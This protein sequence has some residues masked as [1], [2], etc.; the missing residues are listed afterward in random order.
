[1]TDFQPLT[2]HCQCGAVRYRVTAPAQRFYHCHCAMCRRMHGSLFATYAVVEREH[3]VIDAGGEELA[4]YESSPG[5][6]RKRCRNCACQLFLDVDWKPDVV[7]YSPATAEGHPGHA[8]E[9]ECHVFV[10]SK[11]SWHEITDRLPRHEEFP[12]GD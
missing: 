7:W 4:S 3:L 6:H 2:G 11:A 8:A 5:V 1:M 10:G 9:I 12:P